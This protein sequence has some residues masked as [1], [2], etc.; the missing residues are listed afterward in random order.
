MA[1]ASFRQEKEN[2]TNGR[3]VATAFGR[4]YA[5]LLGVFHLQQPNSTPLRKQPQFLHWSS[6]HVKPL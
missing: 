5:W 2:Q 6:I 3:E 1:L 4:R